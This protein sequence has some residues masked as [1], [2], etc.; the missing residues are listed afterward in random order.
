MDIQIYSHSN[1]PYN[2]LSKFATLG[3]AVLDACKQVVEKLAPFKK[4]QPEAPWEML[5]G[6]AFAS[7]TNL[8]TTGHYQLPAE[9]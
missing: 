1:N 9:R 7:G 2:I 4:A 8:S 5:V 6:M 3:N